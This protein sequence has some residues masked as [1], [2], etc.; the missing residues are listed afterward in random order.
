MLTVKVALS[1]ENLC[2]LRTTTQP[3][4][5]M[6]IQRL[7]GRRHRLTNSFYQLRIIV[8]LVVVQVV[9]IQSRLLSLVLPSILRTHRLEA[10]RLHSNWMTILQ[11]LPVLMHRGRK[12]HLL[13][14]FGMSWGSIFLLSIIILG[15][16]SAFL[17]ALLLPH[18]TTVHIDICYLFI[19]FSEPNH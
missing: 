13:R 9:R 17:F 14:C 6:P 11:D 5:M 7:A 18:Y 16:F 3:Q 2:I 10:Q 19:H 8:K 12:I 15:R 1:A 4:Q